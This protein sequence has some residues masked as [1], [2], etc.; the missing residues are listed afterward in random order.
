[1][2]IDTSFPNGFMKK[3]IKKANTIMTMTIDLS[4]LKCCGYEEEFKENYF[5]LSKQIFMF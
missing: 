1:M 5:S 4:D 2:I 3:L